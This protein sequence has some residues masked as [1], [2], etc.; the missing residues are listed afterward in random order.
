GFIGLG[1]SH[2]DAK[3]RAEEAKALVDG[4]SGCSEKLLTDQEALCSRGAVR[5]DRVGFGSS[6]RHF[7][8]AH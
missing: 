1:I 5:F 4:R 7:T 2:V 8:N 3:V 6:H